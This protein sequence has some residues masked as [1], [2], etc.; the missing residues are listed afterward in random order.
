[1]PFPTDTTYPAVATNAAWQKK[2]SLTDKNIKTKVGPALVTAEA[3][4]KAIKFADL[5][6]SKISTT[7][8]TAQAALDKANAAWKEVTTARQSLKA[9]WTVA[10]TQS[11]NSKLSSASRTALK[12][13]S[14]A[15]KAADKR[16]DLMDD[17]LPAMQVD[18]RNATEAANA[19][20]TNLEIKSGSKIVAHAKTATL[21][22]N[23]TYEA[24]DITWSIP[25][26]MTL[27]LLQKK[28]SVSAHD[29]TGHLINKEMKIAGITGDA[30]IRLA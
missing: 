10:D 23:K 18:L 7:P 2:K 24:H 1:M 13:I 16:L 17:I 20:W 4:W 22:P 9:A 15:L 19:K 26:K 29:G 25:D 27:D 6:A 5:N 8:S 11:A 21:M 28:V 12:A 14:T 30:M 3:N